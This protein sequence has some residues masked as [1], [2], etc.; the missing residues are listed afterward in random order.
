MY[1]GCAEA[2][3]IGPSRLVFGTVP[4]PSPLTSQRHY[5]VADDGRMLHCCPPPSHSR[6]YQRNH[7]RL[8][9]E[10]RCSCWHGSGNI[11][12]HTYRYIELLGWWVKAG[13]VVVVA[14]VAAVGIAALASTLTGT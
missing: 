4:T 8:T 10:D 5:Y 11:G 13:L 9:A 7:S 14:G 1:G 2:L 12:V 6:R 3:L